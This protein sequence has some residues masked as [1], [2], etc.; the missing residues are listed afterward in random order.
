VVSRLLPARGI[1]VIVEQR[2]RMIKG[3]ERLS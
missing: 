1:F 3:A 2:E